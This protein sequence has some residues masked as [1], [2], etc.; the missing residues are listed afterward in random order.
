MW[1]ERNRVFVDRLFLGKYRPYFWILAMGFLLYFKALSFDFSYL[2]DNVLIINNH[3]F[4]SEFSNILEVFRN[5]DPVSKHSYYRPLLMVSLI[6]DAQSG[7]QGLFFYHLSNIIFHIIA[8][9][10]VFKLLTKMGHS[11]KLSLFFGLMFCAHPALTNPV[12][13]I[14]GRADVLL[15]IFSLAAFAFFLDF[16][17]SQNWPA[18]FGHLFFFSMAL[19][20]RENALALPIACT[21]YFLFVKKEKKFSSKPIFLAAGWILVILLWFFLRMSVLTEPS[22]YSIIN[23][24]K[25]LALGI[26]ALV[27]YF[28]K[29]VFP[30]NLSVLPIIQDTGFIWGFSALFLSVFVLLFSKE[31]R[32]GFIIFGAG[33]FFAFLAL[34]FIKP[35]IDTTANFLEHRL[36][37]GLFGIFIIFLEM[38][39]VKKMDFCKPASPK[40]GERAAGLTGVLFFLSFSIISFIYSENYRDRIKFW[41][42]AVESSPHSPLAHRNLGAIYYLDGLLDDAEAEYKK[43]LRLNPQEP[44]AHN[45]LGLIYAKRGMLKDAEE[46]YKKEIIV[47]PWYDDVYFNWGLLC[48]T[49]GRIKEAEIL[50][51]KTLQINPSYHGFCR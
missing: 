46:E 51:K 34:C 10:L 19:L 7:G 24:A 29:A 12:V 18:F 45:N 41:N 32:I 11:R 25:S 2:D 23:A 28:G 1:L 30:F 27:Q 43:S 15:A 44:M 5:P 42:N 50:W 3:Q 16:L 17:K 8:S 20:S 48:Y 47:N 49:Q 13:W 38:D 40:R 4:I 33:W 31:K 36:Y 6:L 14:P 39:F 9:S 26:P 35:S 37:P 21:C 22:H